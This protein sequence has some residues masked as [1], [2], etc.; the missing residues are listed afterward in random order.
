MHTEVTE[1]SDGELASAPKATSTSKKSKREPLEPAKL[2]QNLINAIFEP[3]DVVESNSSQEHEIWDL[4]KLKW[5]VN[6]PAISQS[7]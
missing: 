1:D 2:S 5:R 4:P 7:G 6:G 3:Q